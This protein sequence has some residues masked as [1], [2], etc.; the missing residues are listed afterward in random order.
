MTNAPKIKVSR[1][2]FAEV[3]FYW[4]AKQV[5]TKI[6]KQTAKLFDLKNKSDKDFDETEELFGLNLKSK[7][8]FSK[9]FEELF[10]VNMWSIVRTCE[11][12]FEDIDKR[13]EYLDMFHHLV[14]QRLIEGSGENFR[15]WMLSTTAKYIDYNKI[16][17]TEH[18]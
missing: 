6:I 15:Q 1:K 16:T 9:L 3:L 17:E 10:A 13:N 7:K 14:Y 5:N 4:L 2:E 18:P 12:V 11:R 8:E